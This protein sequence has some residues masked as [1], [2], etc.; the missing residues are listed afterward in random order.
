MDSI[1]DEVEGMILHFILRYCDKYVRRDI[2]NGADCL[3]AI[4]MDAEEEIKEQLW[5]LVKTELNYQRIGD[6]IKDDLRVRSDDDSAND[7]ASESEE[8]EEKEEDEENSTS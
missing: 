1:L 3:N 4:S 6:K 8:E 5:H 7:T 2:W